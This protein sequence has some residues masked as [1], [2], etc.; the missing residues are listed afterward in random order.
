MKISE[1][2]ILNQSSLWYMYPMILQ[3]Q[4]D[5]FLVDRTLPDNGVTFYM[6]VSMLY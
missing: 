4:P 1:Y 5:H 2:T 3:T 6:I